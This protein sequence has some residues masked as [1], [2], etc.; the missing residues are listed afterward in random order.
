MF[1]RWVGVV[2]V[3]LLAASGVEINLLLLADAVNNNILCHLFWEGKKKKK[4][5]QNKI[6]V[7]TFLHGIFFFFQGFIHHQLRDSLQLPVC[8]FVG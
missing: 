4:K 6:S 2:V 3:R 5:I 1:I 7:K 8:W